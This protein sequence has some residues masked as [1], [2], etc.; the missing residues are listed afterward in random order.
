MDGL[1]FLVKDDVVYL[2]IILPYCRNSLKASSTKKQHNPLKYKRY[3]FMLFLVLKTGTTFQ[4]HTKLADLFSLKYTK[5][6][7]VISKLLKGS[8]NSRPEGSGY[9]KYTI[10]FSSNHFY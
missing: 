1:L 3:L 10:S 4:T 7:G 9:L 5:Q 6:R 2:T 8:K